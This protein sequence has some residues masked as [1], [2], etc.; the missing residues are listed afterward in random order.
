M[1]HIFS[2]LDFDSPVVSCKSFG[3]G[4][5]NKSYTVT[6]ESG[7]KY[8][9]QCINSYV[10]KDGAG[11]MD[12]A[13]AVS[14]HIRKKS[15]VPG[16][17][18]RFVPAKD[19]K[20]YC[21]DEKGDYWRSYYFIDDC[22]C[23]QLPENTD[24]FYQSGLAFGI[25]QAQ[26]NDFPA[27]TLCVTIPGFH[28]TPGRIRTFHSAVENDRAGRAKDAAPE[29]KFVLD[30]EDFAPY[31]T[32]RLASGELPL[33]VTHNDTK[34][35]NVLLD[36][37]THA[38]KC[39]IDL[40]TVMPGLSAYDFGDA[41]RFGA[42]TA[43][44]D[45]PD[46]SKVT[47]DLAMYRAFT[48]GFIQGFPELTRAEKAALPYGA[49]MLCYETGSRFLADYLDGDVYFGADY[50]EHNLVRARVQFKMVEE[51][52]KHWDEMLRIVEEEAGEKLF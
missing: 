48:R 44:E 42:C 24:D 2:Q 25:F 16:T 27:D 28:D 35:N 17:Y 33:R 23:L 1:N 26:L 49:K 3:S 22:V 10:F 34:L 13:V 20:Y 50:P 11:L 18:L 15:G 4:H 29:I 52:E 9:L 46:V 47:I 38:P 6:T 39:I 7:S 36:A 21:R 31:L 51:I 5:I 43:L 8:V 32:D 45:E 12:N 30:R 40:D 14:E 37:S 19:G 41:I